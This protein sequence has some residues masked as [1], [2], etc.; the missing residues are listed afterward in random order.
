MAF[1][2]KDFTS[3]VA[4]MINF[5]KGTTDKI[6]DFNVGSV[7]RTLIEA[8]A[9]E[10]DELYQQMF[11]GLNEAIP[12]SLYTSLNFTALPA[13][14][15]SGLI[16]VTYTSSTS[17]R[18]VP[19]GTKFSIVSWPVNYTSVSDVVLPPGST[20]ADIQVVGDTSG[21]MGNV[22]AGSAFSMTP[23][24]NGFLSASNLSAFVNGIDAE[25][26]SARK[27]R[28]TQFISS[29]NRGTNAALIYGLST[30]FLADVNGNEI[31]RVES[32]S[33]IEP[34]VDDNTQP[35]GLVNCYIHNGVGGTSSALVTHAKK[36]IYGY[37][38]ANNNPIA[39][40]KAAGVQVQIFAATETIVNVTAAIFAMPGYDKPALVT[41][42]ASAIYSYVQSLPIGTKC[43]IAEIVS[44][45]MSIE[46]VYNFS[47][48][49]PSADV[50]SSASVKLMPGTITI[51]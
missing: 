15:A 25:S 42:A 50:S 24:F 13:I 21:V 31:E 44:L 16:R 3:I 14:P 29:L 39:G 2:I 51:S 23:Q 4:S 10:I 5:M 28:F 34:W 36:V 32:S 47:V 27:L 45:V 48:T 12:V 40:W 9:I 49:A 19:A 1:Q 18:T 37:Y 41:Q 8:P 26:D 38:D 30:V 7:A 43:L 46:G 11:N 6:T 22:D 33:I 35:V 17:S 20:Y